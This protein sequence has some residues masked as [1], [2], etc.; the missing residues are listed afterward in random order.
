MLCDRYRLQR[1][2]RR[3]AHDLR[4]GRDCTDQLRVCAELIE[5]SS[6]RRR[7]RAWERPFPDAPA[8]LPISEHLTDIGRSIEAQQVVIVCGETGSGK[9]TQLPQLCLRLGRGQ[10]G[11]IGHTQPRRLAARSVAAR[12]AE[13]LG[14]EP[15]R[16]VGYKVRYSD[17][18]HPSTRIKLMTDGLLLAEIQHDRLLTAY[19][20]LIID[21]AHERSLNIDF[22]LGYL[23]QLLPRRPDLKVII[24]SATIDAGAF[25]R[26]FDQAPVIEVAGRG[27]PVEMRYRPIEDEET[28]DDGFAPLLRAVDELHA[29]GPG[30]ILVFLS[31]EREIRDA[32]EALRHH[33]HQG[34]DILPLYA[35]LNADQQQQIFHPRGRR[36][37]LATNIAETSLTVPGI[38][39]VIDTGLARISRYSHRSKVQRL[40]V[41]PVSQASA[42]QR[43]G[44]CGRTAPGICVR[45]Y[46][47]QDLLARPPHTEPEIQRTNLA[48]V[49]LQMASLRL[50][51]IEA[52]PFLDPPDRRLV[53]DGYRL[54]AEL[55]A[56]D[57]ERRLTA[58]GKQLARLMVDPRHGRMLLAATDK[59]CLR[60]V[61]IIVA[62]LACQDPRER[63]AG[64]E[65]LA[66][67]RQAPFRDK[68]SDFLSWLLLWQGVEDACQGLSRRQQQRW[69]RDHF[70]SWRRLRE[71][72]ESHRQLLRVM[73]QMG[74]HL[75]DDAADYASI[76]Q[77]LLSGLLGHV[78][79]RHDDG[80]YL[81]AR[82]VRLQIFPGSA[83]QKKRPR[84]IMAGLLQE[85]RRL[86]AHTVARI[87]PEWVEA[88]A[89]DY[90][91]RRHYFD[92]HWEKRR[93]QVVA[94]LQV[95]LYGLQLCGRRRVSFASVDREQCREIFLQALANG[96]VDDRGLPFLCHNEQL[97]S[98]L[99][100]IEDK[101]RRR[102]YIVDEAFLA[103][104]YGQRLPAAIVDLRALRRWWR[105]AGD[106]ERR[107]LL[108]DREECQRQDAGAV[109]G[110]G[111]PDEWD[112]QGVRLPLRYHFSPGDEDD[113]VTLTVPEHVL[114]RLDEIRLEWLVPGLIQEKITCLIKSLPKALRRRFIPVQEFARA[115]SE[116][117]LW[118]EGSL[119]DAI[120]R[121]LQRMTGVDIP[122][123]AW[124]SDRLPVHLRM[125]IE[126]VDTRGEVIGA[127]RELARL[128]TGDEPVAPIAAVADDRFTPSPVGCWGDIPGETLPESVEQSLPGMRLTYY[129]ALVAEGKK[130][131]LR[132]LDAPDAALEAHA[133]GVVC[134]LAN[135]LQGELKKL[136]QGLDGRPQWSL[137]YSRI[138]SL[139]EL[140]WQWAQAV[141]RQALADMVMPRD[142]T[143]W[144]RCRA[145]ACQQLSPLARDY[146]A[147]LTE[148]MAAHV[149]IHKHLRRLDTPQHL[150]A[151]TDIQGQLGLL[152]AHGFI[153][154]V[155]M[156]R[157]RH[158]GRYLQAVCL[159]LERLEQA[160]DKDRERLLIVAP[161]WQRCQQRWRDVDAAVA[162]EVYW[163]LEE[164][165][166]S[167]FAQPLKT[168]QK[169][170]P[171]RIK[172]MLS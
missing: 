89:P 164:L 116:A 87:E 133:D 12:L 109:D 171:K 131:V 123:S 126:V 39:Y 99:S 82:G 68:D 120:A 73:T 98:E 75:N 21:E 150:K 11:M 65:Q 100:V 6:E 66:D 34:I 13:E 125:R 168:A 103:E 111:F 156:S 58:L 36:I 140:Q 112:L 167:L 10:A 76:H 17:H 146:D 139:T 148:I 38:R 42:R 44:R 9:T 53:N 96:D 107:R 158:Y 97:L 134:L 3:L 61:L 79:R 162:D 114:G 47:E 74:F 117:L 118:G 48:S 18:T 37:V 145:Q 57:A 122:A 30:D 49:I 108:L 26:H 4:K 115:C 83:L 62:G 93:G 160:P 104:W 60:E 45:L 102:D 78:A 33:R 101:L 40:P 14:V 166:V 94:C 147:L 20:T 64:A 8:E 25:A 71:W 155:P 23:R 5:R 50:G 51:E 165:R 124:S 161:L 149:R 85:T 15:G 77:A 1:R 52:F 132:Y 152:L 43:A 72:R 35:R 130:V 63:P 91:L 135:E 143:A 110:R 105:K 70:I 136:W 19:D 106:D 153:E 88:V 137:A 138:G 170:S 86:Y 142:R 169:V 69:C 92:P 46:S 163:L 81:G 129:P 54:L 151:L 27:Y 29:E 56:L 32:A 121:Q 67:Q 127:G 80:D 7:Q 119:Q 84:W 95:T 128:R 55:G 157:L 154:R 24:T 144:E 16:E 141:C 159:R 90:L 22:L 113:G 2:L 41:E 59:A 28:G 31:G 172:E